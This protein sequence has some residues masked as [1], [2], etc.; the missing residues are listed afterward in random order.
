M[1]VSATTTVAPF[2]QNSSLATN[3]LNLTPAI[4]YMCGYLATSEQNYK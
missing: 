4:Q 3:E 2:Q 1:A